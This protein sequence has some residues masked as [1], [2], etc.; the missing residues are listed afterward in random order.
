MFVE[1]M[2]NWLLVLP[3]ALTA[4]LAFMAGGFFPGT[5]GLVAGLLCLLLVAR[6]TLVDR[7]FAG[8]S[9]ALGLAAAALG[10][11]ATWILLSSG[12]SNL[13]PER[14]LSSI[15]RCCTYSFSSWLA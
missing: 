10:L 2:A 12:W 1:R 9:G 4:V 8:W 11:F 7:P 3:G 6:V 13:R 5:T 15:A 14:C